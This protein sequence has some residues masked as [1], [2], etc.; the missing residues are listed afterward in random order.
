MNKLLAISASL[1]GLLA[2]SQASAQGRTYAIDG[3]DMNCATGSG[4]EGIISVGSGTFTI[5]ETQYD[6]Q[7]GLTELGDGWVEADY[8]TM[9][10]GTP[11]ESQRIRIRATDDTVE[12][13]RGDGQ[14]FVGARCR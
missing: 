5:T 2:A 11:G 6:R 13:K 8:A 3:Y 7:S 9:E 12:I 1:I 4:G 10:E 14:E